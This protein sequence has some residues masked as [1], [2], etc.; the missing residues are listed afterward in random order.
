MKLTKYYLKSAT[1]NLKIKSRKGS[2]RYLYKNLDFTFDFSK[3][4][5]SAAKDRPFI[6][7]RRKCE[8]GSRKVLSSEGKK[9]T[10]WD[11]PEDKKKIS[12]ENLLRADLSP[13]RKSGKCLHQRNG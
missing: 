10:V 3:Q 11:K 9:S 13:K 1:L 7:L 8:N 6:I 2:E 5:P 4:K 12:R